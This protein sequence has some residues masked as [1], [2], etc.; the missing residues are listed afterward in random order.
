MKQNNLLDRA[1]ISIKDVHDAIY[2]VF[3]KK[4]S[5]SEQALSYLSHAFSANFSMTGISGA[6]LDKNQVMNLFKANSGT[7]NGLP[8]VTNNY[9]CVWQNKHEIAVRYCEIQQF[10]E[11][12]T[13]RISVVLLQEDSAGELCWCYLHETPIN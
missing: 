12:I 1:I 7:K 10:D 13:Q 8:I 5:Q 4:N 2:C 3:T 6:I 9:S 11:K